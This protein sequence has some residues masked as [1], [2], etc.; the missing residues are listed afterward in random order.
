[1]KVG[2]GG[3]MA[4]AHDSDPKPPELTKKQSTFLDRLIGCSNEST[5]NFHGIKN[6]ALIDSGSTVTLV[7]EDNESPACFTSTL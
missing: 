3:Q 2:I 6:H 7:S 5:V 1:M 4:D